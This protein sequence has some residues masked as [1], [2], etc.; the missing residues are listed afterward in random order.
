MTAQEKIS[1]SGNSLSI[2]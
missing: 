2:D 1:G